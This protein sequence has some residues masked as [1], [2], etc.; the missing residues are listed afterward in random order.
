MTIMAN[1]TL[2]LP[3]AA[4]DGCSPWAAGEF[5]SGASAGARM[6]TIPPVLLSIQPQ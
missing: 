3:A 4:V 6:H 2:W 5:T 1:P